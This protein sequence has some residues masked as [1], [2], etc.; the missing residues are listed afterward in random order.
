MPPRKVLLAMNE[1]HAAVE[2]VF[3]TQCCLP[4]D[5]IHLLEVTPPVSDTIMGLVDASDMVFTA[6]TLQAQAQTVLEEDGK[7]TKSLLEAS[8][9]LVF[10]HL[11]PASNI[12]QHMLPSTGGASGVSGTVLELARREA[13]GMIVVGSRGMGVVKSSL[14]SLV[15]LG[16]VGDALLKEAYCPVL[17]VRPDPAN[18]RGSSTEEGAA[19]PMTY[20]GKR[21]CVAYD[22]SLSADA[23]LS[24][25][26]KHIMRPE[27]HLVIVTIVVSPSQF[28]A[29]DD[30]AA[31]TIF[32][33]EAFA[34]AQQALASATASA[35]SAA[36]TAVAAVEAQGV[37]KSNIS[38]T[39]LID[40]DVGGALTQYVNSQGMSV[41]VCGGHGMSA[42]RSA[43][44]SFIG[45]G[46][47]STYLAHT[48]HGLLAVVREPTPT[49]SPDQ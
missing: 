16:S 6:S 23:A 25:A 35:V 45:L 8:E 4:T 49:A 42:M 47:V 28:P 43:M 38:Q 22:G 24:W 9:L 13:V 12:H 31:V 30:P 34:Q 5:E 2:A 36:E 37:P 32:S 33:Q 41:V 10:K 26:I 39:M 17:L 20:E 44:Q 19:E 29:V 3:N 7:A 21:V 14:M 48:V 27:D 18:S 15:G 11:V 1:L 46:S 40:S